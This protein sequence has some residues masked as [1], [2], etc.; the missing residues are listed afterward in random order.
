LSSFV[1]DDGGLPDGARLGLAQAAGGVLSLVSGEEAQGLVEDGGVRGWL[2]VGLFGS[3]VDRSAQVGVDVGSVAQVVGAGLAPG[4][5]VALSLRRPW[6]FESR[7]WAVYAKRRRGVQGGS[8]HHS[9]EM[10][11]VA[12]SIMAGGADVAQVGACLSQV[13]ASL[14]GFD[15]QVRPRFVS[16]WGRWWMWLGVVFGVL[17]GVV[18]GIVS[19]SS[20]WLAGVAARLAGV[21]GAGSGALAGLAH[22]LG[23]LLSVP[24]GLGVVGVVVFGSCVVLWRVGLW[25]SFAGRLRG[26]RS[27]TGLPRPPHKW[28][29]TKRARAAS[30]GSA[31]VVDAFVGGDV[32][33]GELGGYPLRRGVFKV[34]PFL[35]VSFVS[36]HGGVEAGAVQHDVGSAPPELCQ[37]GV[38]PVFGVDGS[39]ATVFL[40][41]R[42]VWSG[43]GVVGTPG[44]GKSDLLRLLWAQWSADRVRC[45]D[46]RGGRLPSV[47]EAWPGGSH[48]LVAFES[49]GDGVESYA[50]WNRVV[51]D[52]VRVVSLTRA[53]GFG[54]DLLNVHPDPLVAARMVAS[55]MKYSFDDGAIQAQSFET[56]VAVWTVALVWDAGCAAREPEYGGLDRCGLAH[57]L[58]NGVSPV[59]SRRMFCA[60]VDELDAERSKAAPDVARVRRLKGAV[61]AGAAVFGTPGDWASP[62]ALKDVCRAPRNKLDA[63]R[64]ARSWWSRPAERMLGW[65]EVL[66]QFENVVVDVSSGSGEDAVDEETAALMASMLMYG[67]WTSVK[68]SCAGWGVAGKRV[69]IMSDELALIAGVGTDC[70]LWSKD[71]GRSSG[72]VLVL[73]TQRAEQL[74]VQLRTALLSLSNFVALRQTSRSVADAVAA[75]LGMVS[76]EDVLN[77]PMFTGLC[78]VDSGNRRL[79]LFS[80]NLLDGAAD[81]AGAL[82]LAGFD[83]DATGHAGVAGSGP[84]VGP[85]AAP[86]LDGRAGPVSRFSGDVWG[87]SE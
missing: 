6:F 52:D 62:S 66:A 1:V 2:S 26:A 40:S 27:V 12:C 33:Q 53:D 3:G 9:T 46:G 55:A 83:T 85:D 59:V 19:R 30:Q 78:Q 13:M 72:A 71:Q 80:V 70:L 45:R 82:R 84:V 17:W 29:P 8:T 38:G 73:A 28:W 49:K 42:D 22:G 10:G 87:V 44:S 31:G 54:V 61:D 20:L 21:D 50:R 51:G 56:L 81:M 25:P 48:A 65:D 75:Q 77:L 41:G 34:G 7:R 57:T 47:S 63:L 43:L 23:W 4:S 86:P 18:F 16:A 11:A 24:V 64:G 32:S 76:G 79:P 58:C 35:L 60:V 15:V 5:W 74:D 68:R 39:G 37:P 67:L 69:T 36:P 14:P